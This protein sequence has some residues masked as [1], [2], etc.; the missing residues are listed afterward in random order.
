[1]NKVILL[2]LSTSCCLAATTGRGTP[3][4]DGIAAKQEVGKHSLDLDR[5]LKFKPV[6]KNKCGWDCKAKDVELG[7]CETKCDID[8]PHDVD[9]QKRCQESCALMYVNCL[10]ECVT[11]DM[12]KTK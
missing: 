5:K 9:H 7:V 8:F 10:E 3:N 2:L 11:Y 4:K 12:M 1:M 6:K